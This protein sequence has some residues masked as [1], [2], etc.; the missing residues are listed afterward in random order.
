MQVLTRTFFVLALLAA[1]TIVLSQGAVKIYLHGQAVCSDEGGV[2][3]VT[4]G[5]TP[6]GE[7]RTAVRCDSG[8]TVWNDATA[9]DRALYRLVF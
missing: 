4:A 9:F 2:A 7:P 8:S 3:T 1:A 5:T 6:R